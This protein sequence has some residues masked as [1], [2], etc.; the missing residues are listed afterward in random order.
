MTQPTEPSPDISPETSPEP[1]SGTAPGS[2]SDAGPGQHRTHDAILEAALRLFAE[3]GYDATSMRE[4]AEALGISKPALYYHFDSKEDIVRAIL[5]DMVVQLDDVVAWARE[6]PRSPDLARVIV[7]RWA[8]VVQRHGSRMFRFMMGSHHVVREVQ[9]D[10]HALMPHLN[11][12]A[13]IIAA[14]DASPERVLRARLA[15][16]S[17]NVAGVVGLDIDGPD[18]EILAAA[19]R[20]AVDLL[21]GP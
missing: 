20:I 21:P 1:T 18:E 9:G 6:Q 7:E 15:L 19:R 5:Q 10:K 11:E 2:T 14:D 13:S 8:D 16:M 3:K 17:V 4:I 12:L